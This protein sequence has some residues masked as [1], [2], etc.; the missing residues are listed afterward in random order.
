MME[1]IAGL[2]IP[3]VFLFVMVLIT[4]TVMYAIGRA[5]HITRQAVEA[6]IKGQ[7]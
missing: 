2:L 6:A 1:V 4:T 5:I 7:M 3:I